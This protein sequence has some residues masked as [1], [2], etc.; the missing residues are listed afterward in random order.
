[1]QCTAVQIV[2]PPLATAMTWSFIQVVIRVNPAQAPQ[3]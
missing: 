2:E 1:M 3:R